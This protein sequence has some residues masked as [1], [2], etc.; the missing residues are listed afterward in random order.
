MIMTAPWTQE[1]PT[2]ALVLADGTV[3]YGKGVGAKCGAE[4]FSA[5][6]EPLRRS[7]NRNPPHPLVEMMGLARA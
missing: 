3:I 4:W 2:A 7:V 1:T 5:A 6:V